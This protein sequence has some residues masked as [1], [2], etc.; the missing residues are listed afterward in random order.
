MYTIPQKLDQLFTG[1]IPK[2][3]GYYVILW[4]DDN[5]IY[6][7]AFAFWDQ[8]FKVWTDPHTSEV[9][10][11]PRI[12]ANYRLEHFDIVNPPIKDKKSNGQ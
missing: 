2:R 11:Q 7:Y 6:H 1:D 8:D 12:V 9:Y 4:A 3:E 10:E 5:F